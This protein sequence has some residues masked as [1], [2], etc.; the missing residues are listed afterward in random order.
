MKRKTKILSLLLMI[1]LFCLVSCK[2]EEKTEEEIVPEETGTEREEDTMIY[3]YV[4]GYTLEILPEKNSSAEAFI[5]L[6]KQGDVTVNTRD[7]GNFEKVGP[8]GTSL[9]RNDKQIT[10]EAGDLILYQGDQITLYYDVNSWS[11]TLLG[12]VQGLSQNELKD[13]LG[14]GDPTIVFSSNRHPH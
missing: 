3:A 1:L 11:F 8:L 9:P 6:L 10:T 14:D 7:Y 12:K 4:N 13:I 5:E 2:Q